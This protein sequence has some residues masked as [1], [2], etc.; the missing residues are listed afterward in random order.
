MSDAKWRMDLAKLPRRLQL[1]ISDELYLHLHR[2]SQRT[3]R[4]LRDI[5]A[6]LVC[7]AL[8]RQRWSS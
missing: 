6:D 4:P 2:I 8:S 3:G 5:A 7:Q 1:E